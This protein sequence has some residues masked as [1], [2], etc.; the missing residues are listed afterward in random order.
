MNQ[1]LG[2][3]FE[4]GSFLI[5]QQEVEMSNGHTQSYLTIYSLTKGPAPINYGYLIKQ[6]SSLDDNKSFGVLTFAITKKMSAKPGVLSFRLSMI[7]NSGY[8]YQGRYKNINVSI[9]DQKLSTD[10]L[11]EMV[12]RP[13]LSQVIHF[14]KSQ[15]LDCRN[16]EIG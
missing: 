10:P 12:I 8:G 13:T 5:A 9:V 11:K 3:H 6:W 16:Q 4:S 2:L 14:Q 7:V 1:K 15:P